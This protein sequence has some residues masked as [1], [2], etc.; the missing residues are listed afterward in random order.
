[1]SIL[2]GEMKLIPGN[3]GT[4]QFGY[5]QSFL[6]KLLQIFGSFVHSSPVQFME[7]LWHDIADTCAGQRPGF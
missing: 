7:G 3:S 5:T 6:I 4:V 2:H 1:M